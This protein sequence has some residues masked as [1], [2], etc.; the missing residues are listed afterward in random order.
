[1]E[2][3]K[4]IENIFALSGY[5]NDLAL[6]L[7]SETKGYVDEGYI[8][9][10]GN[11][12]LRKKGTG[13]KLLINVPIS[14][15]GFFI[16]HITEDFKGKIKGVG[17]I[18]YEKMLGKRVRNRDGKIIG[19]IMSDSD[20]VKDEDDLYVDFGAYKKEDVLVKVGDVLEVFEKSFEVGD[21]LY[22]VSV[23]RCLNISA[24]LDIIKNLNTDFDLYYCFS[25]MDNTGFKGAKT[26]AFSINPDICITS[27][28]SYENLKETDIKLNKGVVVR[29]K[30]SHIIVNK[31]LRDMVI[32][33]LSQNLVP[34]QLEVLSN[35]GLSN[36]EI[37]YLNNGILTAN[38]NLPAKEAGGLIKTVN[39]N[40][41]KEFKK[42]LIAIINKG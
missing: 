12:I 17:N 29:I 4:I 20:E 33:K 31:N 10:L 9:K 11:V 8:D 26:A 32:K 37:M 39:K 14:S 15:D 42:G 18:C 23:D 3:I 2:N 5:E 38:I 21:N 36:N 22:G 19:V 13:E 16:S 27:S 35:S 34:Y 30:D 28:L 7:L 41:Y 24:H 25:V 1:M 6:F 40:D